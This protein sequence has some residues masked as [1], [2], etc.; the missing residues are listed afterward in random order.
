MRSEQG[1][2]AV[3]HAGYQCGQVAAEQLGRRACV[4]GV[5]RGTPGRGAVAQFQRHY[6]SEYLLPRVV[7][8]S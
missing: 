8:R 2:V 5:Q 1:E 6:P 3:A 7:H 4:A